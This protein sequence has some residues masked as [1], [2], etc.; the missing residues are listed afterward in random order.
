[1]PVLDSRSSLLLLCGCSLLV[2]L[3]IPTPCQAQF[4]PTLSTSID[5]LDSGQSS[6]FIQD[7]FFFE[8]Q[9]GPSSMLIQFDRGSFDFSG[10][11]K[12]TASTLRRA[13]YRSPSFGGRIC[14]LT[15]SPVLRSNLL[16]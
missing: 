12:L 15:V 4:T 16:I 1:M 7:G 6:G 9:E 13:K 5:N 10:F 11:S 14:P 8:G 3:A 2:F